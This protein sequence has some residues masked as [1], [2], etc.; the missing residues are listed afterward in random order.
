[1]QKRHQMELRG[2]REPTARCC[3][4]AIHVPSLYS[5]LVL[6]LLCFLWLLPLPLLADSTETWDAG[7]L[8]NW[9]R[10]DPL[11][12]WSPSMSNPGDYLRVEFNMQSMAFPEVNCIKADTNASS[13]AFTGNYHMDAVTNISFRIYCESLPPN[14]LQ[15]YFCGGTNSTLWHFML[16][17]PEVGKW[18][19]YSVPMKKGAGW[20]T[21]AIPS[22]KKFLQDSSLVKWAGIKI[23]RNSSVAKHAFRIDDFTVNGIERGIDTD[24]DGVS[25][26]REF[27]AGTDH[28][29]GKSQFRA[30]IGKPDKS[31][32][33]KGV[34]LQWEAAPG[35]AYTGWRSVG[36]L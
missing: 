36:D 18:V 5:S 29:D 12:N 35:L 33:Q 30:R 3:G 1:M 24:R 19:T 7:T 20:V 23:Q 26:W 4:R 15:L 28:R 27:M 21:G 2:A 32:P 16:V 14:E 13:G 22:A 10:Y 17:A 8:S 11:N 34:V 6:C 31:K 9:V 25:D